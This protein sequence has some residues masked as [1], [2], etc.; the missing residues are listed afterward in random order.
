MTG[1]I[2]SFA[3]ICFFCLMAAARG[4]AAEGKVRF[5]D[6]VRKVTPSV[7]AIATYSPLRSPRVVMRGTGFV[8]H[9]GLHVITNAHVLPKDSELKHNERISVLIGRG[10]A[11]DRRVAEVVRIDR[12]HDLALLRIDGNKVPKF[13]LGAGGMAP[14]GTDIAVTGFPIGAVLGL[15]PVTHKGI[16]AA[17][18]PIVIP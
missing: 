16:V 18:T 17:I 2:N 8:V 13:T 11:P 14:E 7:V 5:S 9:D 10:R 6:V 3:W 12:E 4:D 1:L 15:Y